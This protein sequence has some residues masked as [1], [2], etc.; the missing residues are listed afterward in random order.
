MIKKSLAFPKESTHSERTNII[1]SGGFKI[2]SD[3][4]GNSET[5]EDIIEDLNNTIQQKLISAHLQ[6][7]NRNKG[8]VPPPACI[9]S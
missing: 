8:G 5:A 4:D 6:Y 2:L 1:N 7:P 3:L 9:K